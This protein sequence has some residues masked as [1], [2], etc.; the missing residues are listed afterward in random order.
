MPGA[1]AGRVR[2]P[3]R[4]L[5]QDRMVHVDHIPAA[6]MLHRRQL[7]HPLAVIALVVVVLV[8]A[9]P[10]MQHE[11]GLDPA[12]VRLRHQ[13]VDIG[14]HPAASSG[15]ARHRIGGALQQDQRQAQAG[16]GAPDLHHLVTHRLGMAGAGHACPLQ[17]GARRRRHLPEQAGILEQYQQD[18]ADIGAGRLAQQQVPAS[19]VEPG[20]GSGVAQ[21]AQQQRQRQMAHAPSFARRSNNWTASSSLLYRN[22]KAV[23]A[24]VRAPSAV[25]PRMPSTW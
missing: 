23:V 10:A 2:A 16:Q 18:R 6:Q 4:R 21:H 3:R 12:Q 19:Q 5:G 9:G 13:D 25:K 7:V 1:Q 22:S 14:K 17:V 20:D 15:Q 11:A 24:S 8:E